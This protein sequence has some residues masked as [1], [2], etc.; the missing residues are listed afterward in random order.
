MTNSLDLPS[1]SDLYSIGRAYLLARAKR[2]DPGQVD[3]LGSDSNL[4]VGSQ[5]VVAYSLVKQLGYRISALLL[6]GAVGEDLDRYAYDRY[7]IARKGASSALGTVRFFRLSSAL[8][9]GTILAGTVLKTLGG[10]TYTL[11]TNASFGPTQT[12]LVFADVRASQAGKATEV[13]A[14]QIRGFQNAQALF[15]STIQVTNDE[16]TAGGEDVEDDDTFRNR[17]R[18]F[19]LNARRGVLSAIV[20]GA[21][22]VPGVVTAQAVEAI[23][24]TGSGP[25]RVVNLYIADSSGVASA[26]LAR[27][28]LAALDEYRAAGIA[29][30]VSTSIPQL[31]SVALS[32]TFSGSVDTVTLAQLIQ[33]AV[34]SFVNSLPV[35]GP[36][37][38][39]QLYSLLQRYAAQGLVVSQ[40]SIV[41]P[42]GDVVPTLGQTLRTLPAN[43]TVGFAA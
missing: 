7:Q 12:D 37:Y 39:G 2:I 43:V 35:N 38:I 10:I 21:T 30:L 34:V 6:D 8:G 40:S 4:F 18:D 9:A 29:V 23:T 1:R 14:N 24:T 33:S 15:D 25:A 36:L 28:V 11:V 19:W 13:G 32:L 41:A 17:I 26:A 20:N 42:A 27:Q 16:T 5:S 22:S 3:T 31:V